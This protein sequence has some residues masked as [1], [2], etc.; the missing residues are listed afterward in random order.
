MKARVHKSQV[1]FCTVAPNIV[2]S[3]TAVFFCRTR[4]MAQFTR[5][6]LKAP[7]VMRFTGRSTPV[8]SQDGTSSREPSGA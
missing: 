8:S 7:L 6:K 4:K 3:S 5:T 1:T 2:T